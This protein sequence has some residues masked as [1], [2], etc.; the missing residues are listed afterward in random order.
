MNLQFISWDDLNAIK[1]NLRHHLAVLDVQVDVVHGH[2]VLA[3]VRLLEDLGDVLQNH[4]GALVAQGGR[5]LHWS[6]PEH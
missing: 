1:E 4:A 2:E 3:G 6:V 5:F